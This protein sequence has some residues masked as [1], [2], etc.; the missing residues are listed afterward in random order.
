MD[1]IKEHLIWVLSGLVALGASV[2]GPVRA[3]LDQDLITLPVW[4]VLLILL[5]I[6]V[7]GWLAL[8]RIRPLVPGLN[9][10]V[11]SRSDLSD[12]QLRIM[13]LYV[14]SDH[15]REWFDVLEGVF[16]PEGRLR[17]LRALDELEDDLGLL[18]RR[19]VGGKMSHAYDLTLTGREFCLSVADQ[20]LEESSH[21]PDSSDASD[22]GPTELRPLQWEILRLLKERDGETMRRT[23][24]ENQTGRSRL[25]VER[26][27]EELKE[28]GYLRIGQWSSGVPEYKLTRF[29]RDFVLDSGI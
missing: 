19:V 9:P 3:R 18:E 20:A 24:I 13:G 23:A 4:A 11:P 1:F 12:L 8:P 26:A 6:A 17:L 29:G 14:A 27:V 15:E 28:G 16:E 5:T 7:L 21:E 2:I 10:K 22:N 25:R